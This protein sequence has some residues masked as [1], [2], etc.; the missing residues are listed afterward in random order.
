MKS[1]S[2]MEHL[3]SIHAH[4][5][6]HSIIYNPHSTW[7]D[8]AHPFEPQHGCVYTPPANHPHHHPYDTTDGNHHRV[9][10]EIDDPRPIEILANI[11]LH[12]VPTIPNI[13]ISH[14]HG[15]HGQINW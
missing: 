11:D 13:D 7:Y 8:H 4:A 5:H 1:S 3:H 15:L 2:K 6:D 12:M 14:Q 10:I 9:P